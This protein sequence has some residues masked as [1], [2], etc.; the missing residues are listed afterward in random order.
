MIADM[1]SFYNLQNININGKFEFFS[2]IFSNESEMIPVD[3]AIE[4]LPGVKL[5]NKAHSKENCITEI[6]NQ[7]RNKIVTENLSNKLKRIEL[8]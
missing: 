2:T 1:Q 7:A 3:S 4:H 8:K 6:S 5:T